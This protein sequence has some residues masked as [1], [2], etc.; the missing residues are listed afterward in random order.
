[1]HT[2]NAK[3]TILNEERNK[4]PTTVTVLGARKKK[5]GLFVTKLKRFSN[6]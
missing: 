6:S 2:L 5:H 4:L 1:M 3:F